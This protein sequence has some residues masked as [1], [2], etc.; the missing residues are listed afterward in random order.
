[1]FLDTYPHEHKYT[2]IILLKVNREANKKPSHPSIHPSL[3]SLVHSNINFVPCVT[4]EETAKIL[5]Q[6]FL[7]EGILFL[8]QS[9][10]LYVG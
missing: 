10:N 2:L 7:I 5:D 9:R 4:L 1:M 6:K 3:Q 8:Q